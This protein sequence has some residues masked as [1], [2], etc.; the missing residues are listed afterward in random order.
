MARKGMAKADD[1]RI[2]FKSEQIVN[3]PMAYLT[4]LPEELK[5]KNIKDFQL[6][7]AVQTIGRTSPGTALAAKMKR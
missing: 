6:Y 2:I 1:Y 4:D 7:Y 5:A 3:S